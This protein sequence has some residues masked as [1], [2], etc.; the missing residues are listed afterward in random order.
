MRI[1]AVQLVRDQYLLS[2]LKHLAKSDATIEADCNTAVLNFPAC[3]NS[4]WIMFQE[5]SGGGYFC[6]APG[7]IGVNPDSGLGGGICEPPDQVIPTTLLATIVGQVGA[8]T[9]T[10]S[11]TGGS[12]NATTTGAGGA[13]ET[14][15]SAVPSPTSTSVNGDIANITSH[16][17]N[18]LKIGVGIGSVVAIVLVLALCS[19]V[20]RRRNANRISGVS[21]YNAYGSGHSYDE[22]G[23][24]ITTSVYATGGQQF[25]PYRRADAPANNVTVNVVHGDQQT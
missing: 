8:A 3:A 22:F 5:K 19:C 25:E 18:P 11:A 21:G 24:L 20:K 12:S 6:C 7:Q 17:S 10:P 9:P 1:T 14:N 13:V 16:W 23:N 15:P 2:Q 4:T